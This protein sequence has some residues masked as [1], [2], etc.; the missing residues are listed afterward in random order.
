MSRNETERLVRFSFLVKRKIFSLHLLIIIIHSIIL[1]QRNTKKL[2]KTYKTNGITLEFFE[3]P[4]I[5][6][7]AEEAMLKEHYHESVKPYTAFLEA[8]RAKNFDSVEM[9][10]PTIAEEY[11]KDN[12]FTQKRAKKL[13]AGGIQFYDR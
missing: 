12:A 3:I 4:K 6:E 8:T 9:R 5:K 2:A 1:K 11:P 13:I 7:E 10:F